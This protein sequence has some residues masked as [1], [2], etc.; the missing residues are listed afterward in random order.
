MRRLALLLMFVAVALAVPLAHASTT[1]DLR[2]TWSCCAPGSGGVASQTWTITTMDQAS[3]AFSG[4][5][6][7]GSYTWPITGT[8]TGSSVTLTTGPYDQLPS[9]SA[10]F[11]GTLSADGKTLSGEWDDDSNSTPDG[12]FT[13]TRP[14]VPAPG[15][16][17]EP[18]PGDSPDPPA[19]GDL[20]VADSSAPGGSKL[21]RVDTSNGAKE[22]VHAGAPFSSIRGL[23]FGPD[24]NLYIAD[25][26]ASGIHRLDLKTGAVTRLSQG[27]TFLYRPWDV[28]FSALWPQDVIVTESFLK[29]VVRVNRQSGKVT[30]LVDPM[31]AGFGLTVPHGIATT[32]FGDPFVADF[33]TRKIHRIELLDGHW[34]ATVQKRGFLSAPQ[35]LAIG[36]GVGGGEPFYRFFAS[37]A[38][39]AGGAG[40]VYSWIERDPELAPRGSESPKLLASGGVLK[41][42]TGLALSNDGKTLYVASVGAV[43]GGSIAAVDLKTG[44]ARV[45][46]DGFASPIGIAVAPPKRPQVT[47]GGGS[48]GSAATSAGP[49]GVTTTVTTSAQP[50]AVAVSAAVGGLPPLSAAARSVRVKPV[51][52]LVPAGKAAKVKLRFKRS[53]V[54]QIRAA[55]ADGRA[56]TAK[57][58]V[59]ATAA[60]GAKSTRVKRVRVRG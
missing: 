34:T 37:D 29:S 51:T 52:T 48:G 25:L 9:Y 53:L 50:L 57:L 11:K 55:L 8:T 6:K 46:A 13:A 43:G 40:R 38:T 4:T 33:D 59:T 12:T 24:G 41:S 20:Y 7:G 10:V 39:A 27:S 5:G 16:T 28:A 42:P 36:V 35:D 56:V 32:P 45:L 47:L 54:K 15:N 23:D 30:R 1:H 19:T 22:L 18:P 21:Y 2:G 14:S 44:N 49:T 58:T 31:P 60:N 3:G 17:P 26:G